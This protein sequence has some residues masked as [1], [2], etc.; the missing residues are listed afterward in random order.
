MSADMPAARALFAFMTCAN[1]TRKVGFLANRKKGGWDGVRLVPF[2]VISSLSPLG[3]AFGR[4]AFTYAI[5]AVLLL[6]VA[7][8]VAAAVRVLPWLLDP[9]LPAEVAEP[10]AKSLFTLAIEASVLTGWPLGWSVAMQRFSE[11]GEARVL[12]LLGEA[13]RKTVGRLFPQGLA[14]FA[15]LFFVSLSG[16]AQ[17]TAPGRVVNELIA[18]GRGACAA[19]ES[20]RAYAVPFAEVAWLCAGSAASTPPRLYG[21][22]PAGLG[23]ATFTA[24][25]VD[26]SGD[27]R[28]I[29]L[30]DARLYAGP[31]AVHVGSMRIRGLLPF[32]RASALPP[33]LRASVL[34]L[35]AATSAALAAWVMLRARARG[36]LG[37]L[38]AGGVGVAGP[39]VA[40]ATL[41]LLEQRLPETVSAADLLPFALVPLLAGAT[42]L[43]IGRIRKLAPKA[44]G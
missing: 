14:L 7:A 23:G 11:R 12:L 20:P 32:A 13:P 31:L 8:L 30:K 16:G 27:L 22:P 36:G 17:A 24:A 5:S 2:P 21:K 29:D 26:V 40:L 10:F 41:R 3:R 25:N 15:V 9:A 28:R 43:L 4:P 42:V 39:L 18:K 6:S 38:Y 19:S 35:S 33:W 37:R 44:R 34:G 1:R